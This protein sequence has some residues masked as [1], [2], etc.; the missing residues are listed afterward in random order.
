MRHQKKKITLDRKVGPRTALLRNLAESLILHEKIKTTKAK[1]KAAQSRVER[2]VT[3]AKNNTLAARRLLR[4]D[5]HTDKAVKK[6]MEVLGP[7]YKDRKGGYT[8]LTMLGP[9]KGDG[10][11][12]AVIEFI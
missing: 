3:S 10:S 2:L 4:A 1:A 9:R 6:L 5:L 12:T 11:Q 8:R 7:R